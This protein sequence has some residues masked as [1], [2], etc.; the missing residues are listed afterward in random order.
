MLNEIWNTTEKSEIKSWTYFQISSQKMRLIFNTTE[1]VNRIL[2]SF[3]KFMMSKTFVNWKE[4][5]RFFWMTM[6]FGMTSCWW[7]SFRN[8][9][10]CSS[11][12]KTNDRKWRVVDYTWRLFSNFLL[13]RLFTRQS[14]FTEV[15]LDK[16]SKFEAYS[17]NV[18]DVFFYVIFSSDEII[19]IITVIVQLRLLLRLRYW[20]N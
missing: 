12:R 3:W 2:I 10:D 1:V 18:V 17:W 16:L 6:D 19:S 7:L 11:L 8:N 9:D 20:Q 4:K 13:E 5:E 14:T 15:F